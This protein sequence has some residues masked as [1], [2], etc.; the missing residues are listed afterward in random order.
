MTGAPALSNE[1][2]TNSFTLVSHDSVS[3][4]SQSR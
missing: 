1:I 4:P 2:V 3:A